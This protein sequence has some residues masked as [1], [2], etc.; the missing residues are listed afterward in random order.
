MTSIRPTVHPARC[1]RAQR[2]VPNMTYYGTMRRE[3]ERLSRMIDDLFEL[4]AAT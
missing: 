3:I 4:D 2:P 1:G